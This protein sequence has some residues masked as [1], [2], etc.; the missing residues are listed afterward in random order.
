MIGR[1]AFIAIVFI[2]HIALSN[3]LQK[4]SLNGNWWFKTDPNHIGMDQ[5]WFQQNN[6]TAGWDIMTVPGNWD[7][8]NEY[9]SYAGLAWYVKKFKLEPEQTGKKVLLNFEAVYHD[10]IVWING[11]EIGKSNS[12]FLPFLFEISKYLKSGQENTLTL[13]VDNTFKRGAIWNWGG[14][15]RPVQLEIFDAVRVEQQHISPEPRLDKKD[16]NLSIRLFVKNYSDVPR[17]I[18]GHIIISDASKPVRN[19][20]FAVSLKANES[21]SL[22]L[23]TILK[24]SETHFWHFDDP[25]LYTA[26]VYFDGSEYPVHSDRFGIRKIEIDHASY[27]FRLN[28][29]PFRLMGLNL[30]PDDRTTGNTLPMW[31]IMEDVDLLKSLGCNFT[32]LSHLPLPKDFLDYLDERGMMI[33]SEIPLWGYDPLADPD[34]ELPFEWLEKLIFHQFNHASVVGWSTG[35]EI[36]YYPTANAYVEKSIDFVRKLDSIRLATNVTYTAQFEEDYIRYTDLGMLNKYGKNLGPITRLQHRQHPDKLMFYSEYGIGQMSESL[37]AALEARELI[38]SIRNYPYLMGASIWTFNDYRSSFVGTKELSENRPWGVVDV[39]RR[40]KQAYYDLRKEH[41]PVKEFSISDVSGTNATLKIKPRSKF[42]LPSYTLKNHKVI[43]KLYDDKGM[44]TDGGFIHLPDILPDTKELNYTINWKAKEA[45]S[46]ELALASPQMDILYD[47]IIYFKKPVISAGFSVFGG[48][49]QQNNVGANTGMIRVFYEKSPTATYYKVRYGKD[50]RNFESET[51][52]DDYFDIEGLELNATYNIQMVYINGAGETLS[53]IIEVITEERNFLP[54]GHRYTEP[55]DGG[56]FI[57]YSTEPT[58][59]L[60][61]TRYFESDKGD[62]DARVI[63]SKTPGQMFIPG[64]QNGISYTYQIQ[65]YTDNN[66]ASLWTTPKSVVPDGN[67]SPEVPVIK[68]LIRQKNEVLVT[69][70]PVDKAI[71]YKLQYRET[72]K[73]WITVQLRRSLPVDFLIKGLKSNRS[74]EFRIATANIYGSSEFSDIYTI[75]K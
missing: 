12:G 63:Q 75:Q 65:R 43:Y 18:K 17:E 8:R 31:R 9:A 41:S 47:S 35:N 28:G 7:T 32:R 62:A 3:D 33:I 11:Q 44:I 21:K 66:S 70:E 30:V 67:I 27:E 24:P 49:S 72:G 54:P 51:S 58:D 68:G 69:V 64:L 2:S 13:C 42:D 6:S 55:A 52:I 71:A 53:D 56:F 74:Y 60:Y 10:C 4:V 37:N 26:D 40:K 45:F 57:A 50:T 59:F 39:Y 1:I 29:E 23:K 19:L 5:G 61:R 46:L 73:D 34:Q 38:D 22:L 14:I 48:R 36:G 20:P 25:R 16:A 15:R